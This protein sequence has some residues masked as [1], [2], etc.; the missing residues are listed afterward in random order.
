M[1]ILSIRLEP[2]DMPLAQL[3]LAE[4]CPYIVDISDY[5]GGASTTA[6][7][8][9]L[10]RISAGEQLN[11]CGEV[12]NPSAPDSYFALSRES[13]L[14]MHSHALSQSRHELVSSMLFMLVR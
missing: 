3:A 4:R 9:T 8:G 6:A 13:S 11:V 5:R 10:R 1:D 2:L 14:A 7:N 12:G